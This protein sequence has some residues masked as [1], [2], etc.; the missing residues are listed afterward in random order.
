MAVV[1]SYIPHELISDGRRIIVDDIY[2]LEQYEVLR[3]FIKNEYFL[4]KQFLAENEQTAIL[5]ASLEVHAPAD[6]VIDSLTVLAEESPLNISL[7]GN[8]VIKD[9][10]WNYLVRILFILPPCAIILIILVFYLVLRNFRM[11]VLAIVPAGLAAL[12]TFGSI[13]WSGQDLNLVTVISPLFIIVIGSAYGLH[14]VSHFLDNINKYADRRQLTV[15]TLTMVG[16]PIFLA[17]ITTMAGF[18]SLVWTEVVPMRHMGIFVTLW[19]FVTPDLWR[20]SSY[21][22]YCQG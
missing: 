5:I 19:A 12:W 11:T 22:R 17:T 21:R 3:P 9:T 14:Y 2:I 15:E 4:T 1:Q 10:V 20:F 6:E 7:A 18:A 16:T 8:E 13:F